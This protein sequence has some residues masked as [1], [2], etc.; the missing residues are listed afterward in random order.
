MMNTMNDYMLSWKFVPVPMLI[1]T[2]QLKTPTIP[3]FFFLSIFL[4][5]SGHNNGM[6][7]AYTKY[8][9][10]IKLYYH[11]EKVMPGF[12]TLFSN[13]RWRYIFKRV[14]KRSKKANTWKAV[15]DVRKIG[16]CWTQHMPERGK[17][18]RIIVQSVDNTISKSMSKQSKSIGQIIFALSETG[19]K[20]LSS[21]WQSS[22]K[23]LTWVQ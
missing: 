1:S 21:T 23:S 2:C 14:Q 19:N 20:H 4:C 16:L 7:H 5:N 10:S 6:S 11:A 8:E 15:A 13:H 9:E 22:G 18:H 12:T 17:M 3:L